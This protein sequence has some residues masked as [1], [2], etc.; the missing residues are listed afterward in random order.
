[1][2]IPEHPNPTR[3]FTRL[4][5]AVLVLGLSLAFG[6]S[7][8]R[9]DPDMERNVRLVVLA[10]VISSGVCFIVASSKWWMKR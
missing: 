4:G 2:K 6:L 7:R 9:H 8:I 3:S 10:T 1:M 5:V